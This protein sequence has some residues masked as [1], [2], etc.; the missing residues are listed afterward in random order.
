V[1]AGTS[2][3]I[4]LAS[5][6]PTVVID[7]GHPSGVSSGAK[8]HNGITEVHVAWVVAQRLALLLR[9]HG[10]TVVLTKPTEETMVTNAERA[11]IGNV[12]KAA[13]VVRLHCDDGADSGFAIYHAD[14]QG[15]IQGH[16]GPSAAVIRASAAAAESLHV[17]MSQL[18]AGKLHD[19]GVRSDVKT[20][21]GEAQGALTGSIL[22]EVP[23]VLIE[24]VSLTNAHDATFI[25]TLQGQSLMAQA[26]AHGIGRFVP[27]S[28]SPRTQ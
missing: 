4:A 7:A 10:Y 2:L 14:R 6:L 21:V 27:A 8:V 28:N 23:V 3:L 12:A 5:V 15:R 11:H 18:L 20:G 25:K 19:G 17:S 24:M 9:A 22:S 26:I 1:I 13:L 16:T